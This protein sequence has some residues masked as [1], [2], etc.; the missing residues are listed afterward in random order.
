[1]KEKLAFPWAQTP[2]DQRR[3]PTGSEISAGFACGPAD[4]ELFNELIYRLSGVEAEVIR[5]ITEADL[6]PDELDLTQ[7]LQAL[8]ILFMQKTEVDIDAP[9]SIT[10]TD[11]EPDTYYV[12]F[13]TSN[14]AASYAVQVSTDN[15]VTWRTDY[16]NNPNTETYTNALEQTFAVAGDMDLFCFWTG[17]DG[18]AA[19]FY[20]NVS[21][22]FAFA[23][24]GSGNPQSRRLVN[25]PIGPI[26]AVKIDTSANFH[27]ALQRIL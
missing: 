4:R 19:Q 6:V 24:I 12:L 11:L 10:L 22:W 17:A 13:F 15:G 14:D 26:S 5:V 2:A 9:G 20:T 23:S 18:I 7:L 1:M 27:I 16:R 8:Y 3:E 21:A 25:A